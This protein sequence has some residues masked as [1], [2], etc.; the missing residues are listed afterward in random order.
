MNDLPTSRQNL[1]VRLLQLDRTLVALGWHPSSKWFLSE[2]F[3]FVQAAVLTW[4]VEVGR[5]GGKSSF[6][7]RLGVTQA[8]WGDWE[9]AKGDVGVVAVVS[10]SLDEAKRRLKTIKDILDAIGEPHTATAVCIRLKRRP[11]EF[12]ALACSLQGVV[13]FTAIA[14]LADEVATWRDD[15]GANPAREVL[16][17]LSPTMATVPSAFQVLA[18]SPD[19]VHTLHHE[20]Y[21]LGDTEQQIASNAPTWVA[22]PTITEEQTRELEPN[23]RVWLREYA[24]VAQEHQSDPV[25]NKDAVIWPSAITSIGDAPRAS[26]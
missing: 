14:I 12:R 26:A 11:A 23:E 25:L 2:I 6:L 15:S 3:R 13:G 16:A 17:K 7:C 19:H 5:R 18:S 4:V 20:R 21:L 10:V 24:A 8:V 22:N 9:V 1:L